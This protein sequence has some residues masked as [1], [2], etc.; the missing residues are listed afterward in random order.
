MM[1]HN[2]LFFCHQT[3]ANNVLAWLIFNGI[4][5]GFLVIF[6]LGRVREDIEAGLFLSHSLPQIITGEYA[7]MC[8]Q[9]IRIL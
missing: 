6:S 2:E 4:Q 1:S 9:N 7:N 3:N 5:L 8:I